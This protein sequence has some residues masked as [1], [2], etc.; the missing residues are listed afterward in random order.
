MIVLALSLFL[1][2]RNIRPLK[3]VTAVVDGMT[4]GQ[5]DTD[6]P[7]TDRK[8]EI[9]LIARSL[10]VFRDAAVRNREM[11]S[12]E[13]S[14][15][16]NERKRTQTV[17]QITRQFEAN[18]ATLMTEVGKTIAALEGDAATMRTH[19]ETT[20]ERAQSARRN[21]PAMPARTFSLSPPRPKRWPVRSTRSAVRFR[22]PRK[23][24][25]VR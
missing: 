4:K 7:H 24:P 25:P 21:P 17:E 16:E 10:A 3:N 14:K 6:I 12:E 22:R 2:R 15:G 1:V 11:E 19:A 8:D 20:R 23:S 18:V 13:R 5:L 9:G